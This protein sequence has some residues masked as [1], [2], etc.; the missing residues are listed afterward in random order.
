MRKRPAADPDVSN[1]EA[2]AAA[3]AFSAIPGVL[4]PHMKLPPPCLAD[5]E[6]AG[7]CRW[8]GP[9]LACPPDGL[10]FLYAWLASQ[11][12]AAWAAVDKDQHGFVTSPAEEQAWKLR[13]TA[14]LKRILDCMDLDGQEDMA[15]RLRG[16]AYPGDE[17]FSYYAR[18]LGGA[19]LITPIDEARGLRAIHGNGPVCCELGFTYS[20]DASGHSSG[21]YVLLRSWQPLP[22]VLEPTSVG[23]VVPQ[24][25]ES[26]NERPA[27][28]ALKP[29]L[30]L[31]AIALT[32]SDAEAS[33]TAR[34][35]VEGTE[36]DGSEG[37][38]L[39]D[40]DPCSRDARGAVVVGSPGAG[41]STV[42]PEVALSIEDRWARKILAGVK[43][44]EM[45]SFRTSFPKHISLRATGKQLLLGE[46]EVVDCLG[47]W[48]PGEY[49]TLQ[50]EHYQQHQV[51]DAT[52]FC[53]YKQMFAWVLAN[54][55]TYDP[56]VACAARR[57]AV[58]WVRLAPEGPR[59]KPVAAPSM[60]R[61]KP[62]P[63]APTPRRR[64]A[65]ETCAGFDGSPCIFSLQR[66]GAPA[67]RSKSRARCIFCSQ[68]AMVTASRTKQGKGRLYQALAVFS[69]STYAAASKRITQWLP[70]AAATLL[71]KSRR[72]KHL[73]TCAGLHGRPCKFSTKECAMASTKLE[74]AERSRCMFCSRE[75]MLAVV[76]TARGRGRVTAALKLFKGFSGTDEAILAAALRRIA[77]WMPQYH[78]LKQVKA[79]WWQLPRPV[80]PAVSCFARLLW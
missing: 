47:P 59:P 22:A 56:P 16:G 69:D 11:D 19:F 2:R 53:K 27:S 17:E 31:H 25:P 48:A 80:L 65:S 63:N 18:V 77:A 60:V 26:L 36:G 49:E 5:L 14:L 70:E 3:A 32:D 10:C 37:S 62:G 33:P 54:P 75:N 50:H 71:G 61:P 44:W 57:G 79:S 9:P 46:V 55:R 78:D 42:R 13:A 74:T 45:R 40:P 51:S 23:A 30:V 4:L 43:A 73:P 1:E 66:P 15:S 52:F 6:V 72:P 20:R 58:T 68:E 67:Q 38:T 7:P 8:D 41:P 34:S 28:S 12:P 24:S 29:P 64:G 76:D 21:H 35:L 39:V